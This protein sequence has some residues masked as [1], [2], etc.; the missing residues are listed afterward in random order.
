MML[1]TFVLCGARSGERMDQMIDR[2][3]IPH[4]EYYFE[5]VASERERLKIDGRLAFTEGDLFVGGKAINIFSYLL[6]RTD[7]ASPEF[8]R[9][10]A[11]LRTI[12]RFV[13]QY[14]H[15][16]SWSHLYSVMGLYR[17][18]QAGLLTEIIDPG[19]LAIFEKRFDWR[20]FV[21]PGTLKLINLPT[22]YYGV[23]FG[24]ARYRELLGWERGK[25]SEAL[26]DKLMQHID[27]YSGQANYMD[28][29]EGHGRFDRYGMLIPAELCTMLRDT[30]TP[31]PLKLRTMLRQSSDIVLRLA[32]DRGVGISY[33]R[34][35][36]CYGDSAPA[37]ILATAACLGI[38]TDDEQE[39]AYAYS[40]RI[41]WRFITFW[42]D[43]E[44]RS[45][46]LWDKGRRTDEYRNKNRI[47]GENLTTCMV[48]INAAS[49]WDEAGFKNR[50]PTS[51][52]RAR[53]AA[54]PRLSAFTFTTSPWA[55]SLFIIRDG[56]HI[57]TLPIVSGGPDYYNST[58][59]LP[60]PNESLVLET[61][62]DT[63]CNHLVPKL[64][65]PEGAR[66][67]PLVYFKKITGAESGNR[68]TIASGQSELCQINEAGPK[69]NGTLSC[70]TRYTF[71]PGS[72]E[73]EDTFTASAAVS[74]HE[75]DTLF[76]TF[77]IQPKIQGSRVTFDSGPIAAAEADG[78][79]A[80]EIIPI[81]GD[82]ARGTP[83]GQL[84]YQVRWSKKNFMIEK[85]YSVRVRMDCR[86]ELP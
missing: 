50:A 11:M 52:Y 18:Q 80:C 58:P 81:A 30:G 9:R 42:L 27:R 63:A 70:A 71:M 4:L 8:P 6:C 7:R 64:T 35:I 68:I 19:L 37:Q 78:F 24:I 29:T 55:R 34:S 60:V 23:A 25:P 75:M 53:L 67:M 66:L 26:L 3:I 33:G 46:N 54:L 40:T 43:P 13:G 17:L 83:N 59:Y 85:R 45:V 57:Y 77:S 72:I 31:I 2:V 38:L 10:A 84:R 51:D 69:P 22:N 61:P 16:Q 79:D 73:R 36:G 32:N 14:D 15:Y 44:T 1:Q 86:P 47:L 20:T 28:E 48:F 74:I 21:D 41:A 39:L 5:S 76:L 12:I 56:A 49:Q 62:P 65:L 82:N